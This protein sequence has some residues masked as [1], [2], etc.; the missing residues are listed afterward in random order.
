MPRK[1]MVRRL[2]RQ[3]VSKKIASKYADQSYCSLANSAIPKANTLWKSRT[4]PAISS[5]LRFNQLR[6]PT[7]LA[8][9][10]PLLMARIN[11]EKPRFPK[12][13]LEGLRS[14]YV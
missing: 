8:W 14:L 4:G 6:G 7:G 5:L 10:V 2:R 3:K 1:E 13:N 12:L 11:G 9:R